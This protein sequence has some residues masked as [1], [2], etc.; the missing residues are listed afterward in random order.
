[1]ETPHG[2]RPYVPL[3]AARHSLGD[4]GTHRLNPQAGG[5][6]RDAAAPTLAATR[7]SLGIWD[8]TSVSQRPGKLPGRCPMLQTAVT[9]PQ[10][11]VAG[12]YQ[13]LV[14]GLVYSSYGAGEAGLSVGQ[15]ELYVLL[16][17]GTEGR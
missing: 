16:G 2:K 7:L 17:R 1:M 14:R 10:R 3:W 9:R 11:S 13:C 12:S 8:S 6:T 15:G 5:C 4:S